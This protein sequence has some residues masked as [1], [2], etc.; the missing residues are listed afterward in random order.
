MAGGLSAESPQ[1]EPDERNA[2][3]V[4]ACTRNIAVAKYDVRFM[5]TSVP[6]K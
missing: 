5:L 6:G 4:A 2:D 3:P 1:P